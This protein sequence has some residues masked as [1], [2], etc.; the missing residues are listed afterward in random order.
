MQN[1]KWTKE[2]LQAIERRNSN[3]LVSASAGSG[4]TAV[5]VE[6]IIEK[7]LNEYLDIDKIL[8]V[9]FTNAAAG[10]LK[11]KILNAIYKELGTQ[12]D[13]K[14]INHLRNQIN[15]INKA[16]IMTIDAFCLKL[17]RENFELLDIDPNIK[18][19]EDSQ[20]ALMRADV[21]EELLE[22]K[23]SSYDNKEEFGLYNVLELF[24]GKEE[25][26]LDSI[27]KIYNYIQSFP[28]PFDWLEEQIKKYN[29][30]DSTDLYNIDFSKDIINDVIADVE[31]YIA[32]YDYYMN[33]IAGLEDFTKCY[34]LLDSDSQ[35]LKAV[36]TNI[37]SWDELYN[38]VNNISLDRFNIGKVAD[39]ELK[40]EIKEF[41]NKEVKGLI[42][43]TKKKIYA[44]SDE[45][46]KDNKIAYRY[47]EYLYNFLVEF[48][49]RYDE[50]KK[51]AQ[52]AEFNDIMHYALN[53][54]MDKE[55]KLSDVAKELKNKYVEIY[56][57]EYQDTSFVQEKILD[58][59]SSGN[60]R[61]MVGDIKQSIYAFR[62]ARPDIFTD[63]YTRYCNIDNSKENED[64]K[65]LLSKNFRSRKEVINSINYIFEKIMSMRNGQCLYNDEEAL[66]H[67]NESFLLDENQ[68]YKTEINIIDLSDEKVDNLTGE[69][70]AQEI[71]EDLKNTEIEARCV[72]Y[73]IK[74]IME[75]VKV[76]DKNT[77]RRVKY[78]DI[79][80]LLRSMKNKSE[81]YENA[82]KENGIP[83]FCD[84]SSSIFDGDEVKL[85]MSFLRIIDN[86]YQ[87]VYMSSVMFSIIGNFTLDE[88]TKIRLYDS[89]SYIYDTLNNVINDEEFKKNEEVI[90][91]KIEKF[92]TLINKFSMYAKIYTIPE[93]LI[94][95]YKDT[96]IYYQFSLVENAKSK[97][98]NLDYLIELAANVYLPT[99]NTLSAYIKYV[100][101]LKDKQ[102]SS[103]ASAKII[104]ENEDVVRIMTI[105]K[106]KGLEFPIVILADTAKAYNLLDTRQKIV[107]HHDFGVGIDIVRQDLSITYPSIIKQVVKNVIEKETKSEEM[108]LLYVALTRAKEKLYIF[109]TVRDY[110]RDYEKQ[111]I[112][113]S[114]GKFN[115]AMIGSSSSYYK[116]ILP[117]I[118]YYNEVE[119]N[120]NIFNIKV[121]PIKS[122]T[123]DDELKK[124]FLSNDEDKKAKSID[125]LVKEIEKDEKYKIDKKI[126]S[127]LKKKFEEKYKFYD[128]AN[129]LS[130]VSVSSLKKEMLEEENIIP[131]IIEEDKDKSYKFKAPSSISNDEGYTAVRKGILI[132]FILQ[133]LD[134]SIVSTKPEIKKYIDN[135]VEKNT[136][137]ENDKKYISIT[138]IYNFLNSII[139]KEVKNAKKIYKEYEFILEDKKFSNSLIQGVIDLFYITEDNKVI[140]VDFKTD[141]LDNDQAFI[142]RYKIQLD[143][144]KE[145]IEKLTG[146]KV[147]KVYIY[148]FN[149]NKEIEIK[150][151]KNE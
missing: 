51:K 81:I 138:K 73:K 33:K 87:D 140:L 28:F 144:Y 84:I 109:S 78:K 71:D 145:A 65:I 68:D 8:V 20:A 74:Q 105:H 17:V 52:V 123:T 116:S 118:K 119:E 117:V 39:E 113:M 57:D 64:T 55:Y 35:K 77:L 97:K 128:D 126:L 18:I 75:N 86:P 54:L 53:L 4:K 94:M 25:D 22:E 82:L 143:I 60:N 115:E 150:E 43:R 69:S 99:G 2:Q 3:I 104:G 107:F 122:N 98:A 27:L 91:A 56:T 14:K 6:R 31:L 148:S 42:D 103:S 32:K 44:K 61:F 135:L 9:T 30:E 26:F 110:D 151:D 83:T 23:Y 125:D 129:S 7:V 147:D 121:S 11:E 15:S 95:L 134:F 127:S 76:M 47:M 38:R 58:A 59:I 13:T 93:L 21:L 80:I 46:I 120:K 139:G 90:Y 131:N 88:I 72:A 16:N 19:C 1:T 48:S 10:E 124:I 29:I 24:D 149:L 34:L 92:L 133:N 67:G 5:L 85:I 102:D 89:S 114:N 136:I 106:S 111:M 96:N 79:V 36:I 146:Y 130:R 50:E 108:R 100:D 49:N 132:H 37:D 45:I 66:K 142:K 112:T 41:R 40:E 63:K 141:K 70:N 101:N 137:N 12:T 62:Q